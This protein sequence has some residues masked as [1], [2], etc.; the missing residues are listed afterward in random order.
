MTGDLSA[1]LSDGRLDADGWTAAL[2][3]DRLLGQACLECEHVTAAP[4]AACAR[5]GSRDLEPVELPEQGTV[6]TATRIEVAPEGF[7]APYRVALVALGDARVT[8]RLDGDASIGDTVRFVGA[9]DTPEGPA[10]LFE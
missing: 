8:A 10:P 5:C 1:Y 3:D 6:Y 4:K 9:I 2:A 7:E